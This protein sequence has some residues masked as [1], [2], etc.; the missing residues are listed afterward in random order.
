MAEG[1]VALS[2]GA[3][4]RDFFRAADQAL[5]LKRQKPFQRA[6]SGRPASTVLLRGDRVDLPEGLETLLADGDDVTV[7][8]PMMG[9]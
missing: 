4:L 5:G 6:L 1:V 8:S 3:R 2:P 9:G 7:L